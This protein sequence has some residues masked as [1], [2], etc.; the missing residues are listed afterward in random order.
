MELQNSLAFGS[1]GKPVPQE[2]LKLSVTNSDCYAFVCELV[3]IS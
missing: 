1:E 3:Y 2:F